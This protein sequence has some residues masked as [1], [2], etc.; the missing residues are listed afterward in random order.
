MKSISLAIQPTVEAIRDQA[1]L[2]ENGIRAVVVPHYKAPSFY[3]G[4]NQL[5][6]LLVMDNEAEKARQILNLPNPE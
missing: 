5:S 1:I 2:E 3:V 4:D 6:E